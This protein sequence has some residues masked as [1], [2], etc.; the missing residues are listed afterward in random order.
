MAAI[1]FALGSN[2]SFASAS[3]YFT[4]F[5]GRSGSVWMNYFKGF[6]AFCCFMIVNL[7]LGSQF[8]LSYESLGLLVLSGFL[9]LAIGDIFLMKAFTHLGSGRVL[10]IFGFQPLLLATASY[11]IFNEALKTYQIIAIVFLLICLFSF[12]IESKRQ[13]GH[14]DFRGLIYALL[15]VA[16]DCLGL[17]VTKKAMILSQGISVF[18]VNAIRSGTTVIT[19]L[20]WSYF[21]Y[22]KLSL[23]EPIKNY[24]TANRILVVLSGFFG[25]FLSLSFYM[26]AVQ[27]GHLAT[28][29]AIAGTSPLF[30]TGFEILMGR[31]QVTKQLLIATFSFLIG[32]GLLLFGTNW[33]ALN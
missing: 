6:V 25:T 20:I 32:A 15:G 4:K 19:F 27:I 7:I 10:M 22:S 12:A 17:V 14:W 1:L 29:S 18:E 3:L 2:I 9:G 30:A 24:S 5:A 33:Q 28:I 21:P 11:F 13:K 23:I 26:K 8:H 16:L 31:K